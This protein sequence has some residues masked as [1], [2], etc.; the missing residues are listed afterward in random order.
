MLW[1]LLLIGA[2]I[3]LV[4]CYCRNHRAAYISSYNDSDC[5]L[6]LYTLT[7]RSDCVTVQKRRLLIKGLS[8]SAAATMKATTPNAFG[9]GGC[10]SHRGF[11][12]VTHP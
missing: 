10:R 7:V 2:A 9:A 8:T 11:K 12:D 6:W 5:L 3:V 4:W 1:S